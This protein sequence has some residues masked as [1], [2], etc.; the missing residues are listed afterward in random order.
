MKND[1]PGDIRTYLKMLERVPEIFRRSL[2]AIAIYDLEGRILLGNPAARAMIGSERAATLQGHHFASHMTLEASTQAARD[3]AHCIALGQTVDSHSVFIDGNGQSVPV[4]TRLVPARV[5]GKIVGVIGFARD[6]RP[7]LDVEEQFMRSEQ[8]FRSLFENHPDALALHDLEG[9]FL[10]VNA[11]C[12]RLTGYSVEELIGTT[13]AI[14]APNGKYDVAGVRAAMERGETSQFELPIRTKSGSI[15]IVDGRRVPLHVDGKVRGYSGMIRDV[16]EERLAARNSAH[17]ATRIAELYR[18]ASAAAVDPDAKV[19]TALEAGLTELGAEWAYVARFDGDGTTITHTKVKGP[20]HM[21]ADSILQADANRLRQALE[22]EDFFV[23]DDR[24]SDPPAVA[25]AA[26]SVEGRRYGAIAFAQTGELM[27]ISAGDRDYI[28]A[29]AVLI[30]SAIQQGERNKR[31]DTLAFGDALT[32]L[33][34]RALLQDRLEQTLLSARR[35]RRSFAAHYIDID[36]FKTI[37]DTYGHH[38][39]DAVLVAVSAWLRSVLRDSDTIGRI[40]GDEFVVL[41]P[42]IDSQRQAEE[43]AAKL[44]A[45]RDQPFR[46]GTHDITVTISVGC[47]VFPVDAENPVDMLKAADS[48][49]YDVKNRGRNGYAIGAAN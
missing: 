28:R 15:R 12:E 13:P 37:N 8:Q 18:I 40:G 23:S 24:G 27:R 33:P 31:L 17:R 10:R 4:L 21:P 44:C 1:P 14:I 42:E 48:A 46:V 3:L 43:L 6:Q 49:L 29:L 32:G 16:T 30:G 39:G 9:R 11:A 5:A 45:I 35:H 7:R 2:D 22:E 20:A 34:N 41:Q 36:H 25:G 19:A 47:A 26:L 38:V